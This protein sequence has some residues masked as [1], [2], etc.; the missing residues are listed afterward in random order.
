MQKELYSSIKK[1]ET[2]NNLKRMKSLD[3]D[4][5]ILDLK[6]IINYKNINKL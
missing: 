4:Y 6:H 1:P 3:N 5:Y 2:L